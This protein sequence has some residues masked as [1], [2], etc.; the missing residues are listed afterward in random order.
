M[1]KYAILTDEVSQEPEE[2]IKF[3]EENRLEGVELRSLLGKACKDLSLAEVKEFGKR[4][5]DAGLAV[6]GVA[7]PVYKCELDN[8][9]EVSE[10]DDIFRKSLEFAHALE[11][12]MVRVFTFLRK[13]A[14]S[15]EGELEAAAE[16]LL[17]LRA[18]A[19]GSG[20]WL[21]VENEFSTILCTGAE[22]QTLWKY[23]D[24]GTDGE[25]DAFGLVWDPCNIVYLAGTG[26]PVR[27]DYPLASKYVRHF[28]VKDA[29]R[30]EKGVAEACCEVGKGEVDFAEQMKLL[31]KDG[32]AGWVTLETHWRQVALDEKT[33]HL[34]AGYQ[35]S[36][37]GAEASKICLENLKAL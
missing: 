11:S 26:D 36:K 21:G 23:L 7:S 25:M 34:P 19:K 33:M 18:I 10:H 17:R 31:R 28:H 32:Y 29:V 16:H 5:K 8:E 30:G 35:F 4:C 15:T 3:A 27:D 14:W 1:M 20:V 24:A 9:K 12:D 37:G 22:V 13:S 6:C 2:V